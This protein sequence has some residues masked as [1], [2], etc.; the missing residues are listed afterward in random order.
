MPEVEH[1]QRSVNDVLVDASV[2]LKD[3]SPTSALDAQ[4][5]LAHALGQSRTWLITHARDPIAADR[6]EKFNKL[7]ERRT[8]GTPIAYLTGEQE[9]WSL[10]LKVTDD[11]LI[12]RPETELL[13]ELV[14]EKLP[15]GGTCRVADVG[16][17]SGAIA[18]AI[19]S[20]R[21]DCR[22]VATDASAAALTVAR[23]NARRLNIG[24]VE[25]VEGS[26]LQPLKDQTFNIIV[27]NPPYIPENDPHL[28]QGD[29]RFEPRSAL[30]AG[31]DGLAVIRVLIN[32]GST[33]LVD[34]G[35]LMIEH[36]YD[37]EKV[38]THLFNQAGFRNIECY[39]DLAGLPRASVGKKP[40]TAT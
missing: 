4:V 22:L 40:K 32:E 17:G 23:D 27:S 31:I 10:P 26:N 28:S 13:V 37:Q 8:N 29:V 5:L 21:K 20:E 35:W 39:R 38:V 15:V 9:F 3:V 19:A 1:S 18:L 24:N 14:L 34:D 25:F 12:P 30:V 7:I 6:L 36:G 16:T 33:Y 11:T 2:Q